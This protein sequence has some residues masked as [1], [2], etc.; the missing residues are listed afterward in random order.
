MPFAYRLYNGQIVNAERECQCSM[1]IHP[2]AEPHWLYVDRIWRE[3]NTR[4]LPSDSSSTSLSNVLSFLAF[5]HE[6]SA[7]LSWK[8][9]EMRR[10]GIIAVI[11]L[12]N[13][14]DPS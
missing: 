14:G 10:R 2:E 9:S 7:R 3:K 12:P 6:E 11:E 13:V 1:E 5:Y 4:L 8:D